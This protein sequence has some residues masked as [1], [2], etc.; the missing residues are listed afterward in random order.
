M[1]NKIV[2]AQENSGYSLPEN[3]R[4]ELLSKAPV[5]QRRARR[6]ELIERQRNAFIALYGD[7]FGHADA[8]T[9]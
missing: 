8:T 2:P 4:Q 7:P 1:A 3:V 9:H 6:A 5:A